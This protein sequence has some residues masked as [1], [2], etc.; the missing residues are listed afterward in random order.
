MKESPHLI[1]KETQELRQEL[2]EEVEAT[3]IIM[4]ASQVATLV[5]LQHQVVLAPVQVQVQVQVQVTT[6]ALET[7]PKWLAR[8]VREGS[9][10]HAEDNLYF[11]A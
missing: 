2:L 3:T 9:H 4:E 7:V 10:L 11:H 1:M 6:A 5:R 8:E